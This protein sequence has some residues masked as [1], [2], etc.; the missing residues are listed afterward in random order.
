MSVLTLLK[1]PAG[2]KY[3]ALAIA[4]IAAT[5]LFGWYGLFSDQLS[6]NIL[7]TIALAHSMIIAAYLLHDCGHNAIF[8]SAQHNAYL[9]YAL[10]WITGS[11]YG[12]Y[13]DIRYKHMR[14]HVDNCDPVSFDYRTFLRKHP[15]LERVVFGLEWAYIPAVELI[16]HAMLVL[17]P[18]F[19]PSKS[20]QKARVARI[21]AIRGTLLLAVAFL[22][23]K[24]LLLYALAQVILLTVLRFMDCYQHNYGVVFNLDDP[25]ATFPHRGDAQFEQGTTYSNLVSRRWP[26]LNLLV[27]NF[28]YHNAHHAKPVLGWYRLPTLLRELGETLAPQTLGFW[29]QAKCFHRYRLQRIYAEDY[30]NDEVKTSVEAGKAVGVDAL[31]F[32][33]AF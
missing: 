19:I 16:M 15:M 29:D 12:R 26:W 21:V 17:A 18:W 4:Y 24:A 11:C 31:S 1:D 23:I 30:G 5:Y 7:A 9:G 22:S 13:E 8:K 28:C 25:E 20:N 6:L 3:N 32:L 2:L 27:L 10:N 33:T 14:H